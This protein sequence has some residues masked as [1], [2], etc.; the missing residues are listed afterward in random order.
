MKDCP[1]LHEKSWYNKAQETGLQNAGEAGRASYSGNFETLIFLYFR[2][3]GGA[4]L[5]KQT[6]GSDTGHGKKEEP[7]AGP[8]LEKVH[9]KRRGNDA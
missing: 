4:R 5:R 7:G 3:Q 8:E 9:R 6:K 2:N 1:E